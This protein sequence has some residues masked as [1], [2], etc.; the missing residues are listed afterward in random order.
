MPCTQGLMCL[1]RQSKAVL[2]EK[3]APSGSTDA[4]V[5]SAS[6]D[7]TAA[8]CTLQQQHH[9]D[10]CQTGLALGGHVSSRVGLLL[11][12]ALA[13]STAWSSAGSVG[14]SSSL[15]TRAYQC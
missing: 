5:D 9:H 10:V 13:A 7:T 15:L 12:A 6:F 3:A 2:F 8:R 14:V 11:M 4:G 1:L